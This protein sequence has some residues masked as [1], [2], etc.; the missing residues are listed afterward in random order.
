[1]KTGAHPSIDAIKV[2]RHHYG[3][4]AFDKLGNFIDE[5]AFS[6]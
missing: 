5:N 3:D 2:F 6:V 1:M 4:D